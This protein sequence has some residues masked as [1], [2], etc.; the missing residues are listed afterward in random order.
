MS[1]DVA[2]VVDADADSIGSLVVVVVVVWWDDD[3]C[4]HSKLLQCRYCMHY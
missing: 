3:C 2:A 4:Q 1:D